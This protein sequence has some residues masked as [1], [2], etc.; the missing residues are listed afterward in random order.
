VIFAAGKSMV[1]FVAFYSSPRRLP[2]DAVRV[3]NKTHLTRAR[4]AASNRFAGLA[5]AAAAVRTGV[6][7]GRWRLSNCKFY[8]A[9]YGQSVDVGLARVLAC[10]RL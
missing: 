5:G 10:W 8:P 7:R 1:A 2:R 4:C 3:Q 6:R 9:A